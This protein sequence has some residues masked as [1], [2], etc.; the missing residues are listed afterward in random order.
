VQAIAWL[1]PFKKE[2]AEVDKF[3]RSAEDSGFIKTRTGARNVDISAVYQAICMLY[4][5][6]RGINPFQ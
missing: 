3:W 2:G 1:F 4:A 6:I 5:D